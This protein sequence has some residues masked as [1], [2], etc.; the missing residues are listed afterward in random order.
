MVSIVT[1][2]PSATGPMSQRLSDE[3]AIVS[4]PSI[5]IAGGHAVAPSH[6]C[7]QIRSTPARGAA[8]SMSWRALVTTERAMTGLIVLATLRV[9]L[10]G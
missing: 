5:D 9:G 8:P 2:V 3:E 1:F 7:Y 6:V 10:V 4:T